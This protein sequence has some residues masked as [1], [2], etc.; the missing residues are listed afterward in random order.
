MLT[1]KH[2]FWKNLWLETA[3]ALDP[4]IERTGLFGTET[5][6]CSELR[7]GFSPSLLTLGQQGRGCSVG[8]GPCPGLHWQRGLGDEGDGPLWGHYLTAS[9]LQL[10]FNKEDEADQGDHDEESQENPHIEVLSGLLEQKRHSESRRSSVWGWAH[11]LGRLWAAEGRSLWAAF[12][13]LC[14]TRQG[15]C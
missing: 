5:A 4:C 3:P 7:S 2:F 1:F 13:L 8:A 6:Q 10:D 12:P 9:L 15:F 11:A 14:G